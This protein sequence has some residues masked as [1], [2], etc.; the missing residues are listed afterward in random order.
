MEHHFSLFER[1]FYHTNN[2]EVLRQHQELWDH[3]FQHETAIPILPNKGG[4]I[5]APLVYY[6]DLEAILRMINHK[7]L[8]ARNT[9]IIEISF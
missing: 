5:R 9:E 6:A 4:I 2:E 3:Y 1:C 7:K 8:R